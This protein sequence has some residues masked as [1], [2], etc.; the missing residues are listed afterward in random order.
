MTNK[1][2]ATTTLNGF[3]GYLEFVHGHH[4]ISLI[5]IGTVLVMSGIIVTIIGIVAMIIDI[6]IIY[7]ALQIRA[8]ARQ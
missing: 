2:N 8:A 6:D 1:V 3:L 7:A 5:G 4:I